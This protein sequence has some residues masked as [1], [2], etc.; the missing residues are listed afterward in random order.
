MFEGTPINTEGSADLTLFC[1]A[2]VLCGAMVW[3]RQ[4]FLKEWKL[5]DWVIFK[6][7]RIW[8]RGADEVPQAEGIIVSHL[9]GVWGVGLIGYFAGDFLKGIAIGISLYTLR[10]LAFWGLKF[11][12]RTKI[13]TLE[14]NLVDRVSRMWFSGGIAGFAIIVALVPGI[15]QEIQLGT[16]LLMWWIF[17]SF[18]WM[19]VLQSARRRLNDFLLAFMYLCALEILPFLV[20]MKLIIDSTNA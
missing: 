3:I 16:S 12:T 17:I 13:I 1:L 6:A 8:Q 11:Y 18:K 5:A 2:L 9:I 14:H 19:R 15:S 20:L 10:Q 4:K 7:N